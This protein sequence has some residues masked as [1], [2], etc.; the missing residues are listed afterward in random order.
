M[1]RKTVTL[2]LILGSVGVGMLLSLIIPS[3]FFKVL[4]SAGLIILG[5]I[6]FKN[7]RHTAI[8]VRVYL[9]QRRQAEYTRSGYCGACI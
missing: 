5:W 2:G 7:H 8:L 6:L 9:V 1:C 3:G 4:L